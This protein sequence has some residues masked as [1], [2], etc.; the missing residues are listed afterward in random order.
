[1]GGEELKKIVKGILGSKSERGK[2]FD[3]LFLPD[4]TD[5][6]DIEAEIHRLEF[7]YDIF[8][9][10]HVSNYLTKW[11]MPK[12]MKNTHEFLRNIK[13]LNDNRREFLSPH[14]IPANSG[15]A[16]ACFSSF[17]AISTIQDCSSQL[18]Y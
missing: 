3:C 7:F 6:F 5:R 16:F 18:D 17:E 14:S 4:Y 13:E 2:M 15:Y 9:Q 10:R 12:K 11:M 8:S 1:M